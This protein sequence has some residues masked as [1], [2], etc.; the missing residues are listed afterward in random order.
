MDATNVE[1]PSS[2]EQSKKVA[3][4]PRPEQLGFKPIKGVDFLNR[5]QTADSPRTNLERIANMSID[6]IVER[7]GR[8][9]RDIEIISRTAFDPEKRGAAVGKLRE[10]GDLAR[11]NPEHSEELGQVIDFARSVVGNFDNPT[12]LNM[13]LKRGASDVM[14]ESIALSRESVYDHF[15]GTDQE[16]ASLTW[17]IYDLTNER[18]A[19]DH[20]GRGYQTTQDKKDLEVA[21][22][23]A[24]RIKVS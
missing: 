22:Q 17:H 9:E 20:S 1:I 13:A 16:L 24:A 21:K 23:R 10:Y 14:Q 12:A 18:Y 7:R 15:R 5:A 3:E 4:K 8:W 2:Q 6:N 11:A 19:Q